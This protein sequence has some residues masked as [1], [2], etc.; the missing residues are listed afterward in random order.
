MHVRSNP[1]R[2]QVDCGATVS[3]IARSHIGDT[4][5]ESS[6]ISLEMWNKEKMKALG[7]CE[8]H[9]ENPKTSQ[10]YMVKFV[11]VEEEVTLTL[12]R[13]AGEKMKLIKVDYDKFEKCQ[14]SG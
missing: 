2:L 10:N 11:V 6:N 13:K 7:T 9:L 3:F 8:L 14:W 5:L 4:Q 1:V 12:S